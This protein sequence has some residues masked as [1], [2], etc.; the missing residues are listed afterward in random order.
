MSSSKVQWYV[1]EVFRVAG[2]NR[3]QPFRLA[4]SPT[5]IIFLALR[6]KLP[7]LCMWSSFHASQPHTRAF[8]SFGA[9][10]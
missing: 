7:D 1:V 5:K 10:P 6:S 8:A 9:L 4:E 3:T 2:S